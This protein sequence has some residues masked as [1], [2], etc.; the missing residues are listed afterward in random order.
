M[1]KLGRTNGFTLIELMVVITVLGIVTALAV[2]SFSTLIENNRMSTMTNDLNSTLQFARSE[3]VRRK[4]DVRVSAV[5]GD[6][7]KGLRVWIDDGSGDFGDDDIE[8]RVLSVNLGGLDLSVTVDDASKSNIDFSFNAR[9]ERSLDGTLVL[10]LCDSRQGDYGRK[11]ELLASGALRL[12]KNITCNSGG[13][14]PS[15]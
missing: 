2:P 5:D 10:G 11:L 8:L 7:G 12:T 6:I 3:A 1:N 9:G 13:G 4:G 15:V 14:I